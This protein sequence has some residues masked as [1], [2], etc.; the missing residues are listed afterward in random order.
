MFMGKMY[1]SWRVW[2]FD[3]LPRA[4]LVKEKAPGRSRPITHPRCSLP[5]SRWEARRHSMTM[6]ARFLFSMRERAR[7]PQDLVEQALVHAAQG[8]KRARA[9]CLLHSA[10]RCLRRAC[11]LMVACMCG[12]PQGARRQWG[13]C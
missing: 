3:L 10:A 2:L 6:P 13:H 7:G 5:L 1:Q 11:S 4:G 8:G 9:S 12:M